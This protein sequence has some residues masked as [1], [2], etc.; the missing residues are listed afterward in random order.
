MAEQ[1]PQA[2]KAGK[3]KHLDIAR[4][5]GEQ[6]IISETSQQRSTTGTVRASRLG[7]EQAVSET[8]GKL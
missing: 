4:N 1:K 7:I 8:T 3:K 5:K 6:Q 2:T